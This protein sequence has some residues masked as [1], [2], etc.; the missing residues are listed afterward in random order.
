V[1]TPVSE[2]GAVPPPVEKS[3]FTVYGVH[4]GKQLVAAAGVKLAPAATVPPG[5][6]FQLPENEA[7]AG[8][9]MP[10][11]SGMVI[12]PEVFPGAVPPPPFK[13]KVIGYGVH[14]A[15]QVVATVGV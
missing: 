5:V 6:Q 4:T 1:I 12:T 13:P 7:P 2:L 10:V 15:S 3:K 8:G 11:L 9:V 14:C